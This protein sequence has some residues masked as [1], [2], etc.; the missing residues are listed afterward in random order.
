M[1]Q[2]TGTLIVPSLFL[3][4][5]ATAIWGRKTENTL[6]FLWSKRLFGCIQ[7]VLSCFKRVHIRSTALF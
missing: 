4:L 2:R 7:K 1:E 3:D 6:L 5:T